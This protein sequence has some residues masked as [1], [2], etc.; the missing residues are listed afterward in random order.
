MLF[1]DCCQQ[2]GSSGLAKTDRLSLVRVH[3][4]L[5]APE[6]E[7]AAEA[8]KATILC[9]YLRF[10]ITNAGGTMRFANN[11]LTVC[12]TPDHTAH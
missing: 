8:G 9:P 12:R 7:G 11:L 5:E 6:V 2:Y 1:H 4:N 3:G 10:P